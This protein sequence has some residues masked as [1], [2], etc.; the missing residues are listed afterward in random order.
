MAD[1]RHDIEKYLKGELT[2]AERHA[3]EKAALDDPFMADALEGAELVTAGQFSADVAELNQK[4]NKRKRVIS[5]GILRM[6]AGFALLLV[7]LTGIWFYLEQQEN[8]QL[9]LEKQEPSNEQLLADTVKTQ[10]KVQQPV[11]PDDTPKTF[12]A[13]P[14][15]K[16]QPAIRKLSVPQKSEPLAEAKPAAPTALLEEKAKDEEAEQLSHPAAAAPAEARTL[17]KTSTQAGDA[18]SAKET[19]QKKKPVRIRG[20]SSPGFA[21]A[22]KKDSTHP[23]DIAQTIPQASFRAA[24]A[25]LTIVSGKVVSAEDGSPLPGVSV[26]IKGSAIGTSTDVNGFYHIEAPVTNPTLQY[27]FIGMR[28]AEVKI[29]KNK[30]VNVRLEEDV[31]ALNEVVVTGYGTDRGGQ[32]LPVTIDAA[33]PVNGN[34]EFKKYLETNLRYPEEALSKKIQGRVIVEFTVNY[35][36]TLSDFNIIRSIGSGCDEELIRLIKEGPKWVPAKSN[37]FFVND[38]VR[39]RFK[40]ELPKK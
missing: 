33:H 14:A 25:P 4:I 36:N 17:D 18:N 2:P 23:A 30:E 5:P 24:D 15:S 26:L 20:T 27:A 34:R 6:A 10:P 1:Y 8:Q 40:F 31:T 3:L 37:N 7:S 16:Q 13:P 35:D 39:V 21:S 38:K 9:A 32:S 29:D 28:T 22:V 12:Q 19:G 11:A